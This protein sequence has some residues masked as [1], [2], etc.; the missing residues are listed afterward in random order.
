MVDR[1]SSQHRSGGGFIVSDQPKDLPAHVPDMPPTD[2]EASGGVSTP[3]KRL[4]FRQQRAAATPAAAGQPAMPAAADEDQKKDQGTQLSTETELES[5]ALDAVTIDATVPSSMPVLQ[6]PNAVKEMLMNLSGQND[7]PEIVPASEPGAATIGET[8][9]LSNPLESASPNALLQAGANKS[10]A[11][12]EPPEPRPKKYP[13]TTLKRFIWTLYSP[14]DSWVNS[15]AGYDEKI[16]AMYGTPTDEKR[17]RNIGRAIVV[18]TMVGSLGWLVKISLSMPAPWGV[19]IGLI[20][21]TLYGVLSYSLESFFASNVNPFASNW[22]KA[23]SLT[24]RGLLSAL[25]AFSGALPWVTMSLKGSIHLEMAKMG[26]QEQLTMREGIDKVTGLS[27]LTAR[28]TALQA[29]LAQWNQAVNEMPAPIQAAL[30]SADRCEAQMTEL[31]NAAPKRV[32][33]LNARLP[34]LA[35]MEESARGDSKRMAA[36]AS[37]R[38]LIGSR[39][40]KINKEVGDKRAE[41]SDL[42]KT[43]NGARADHMKMATEQR[44][45]AQMRLAQQRETEQVAVNQSRT[46]TAKADDLTKQALSENSAGEF[47]ALVNLLKTQLFAQFIATLIFMGLFLVDVL[48]LTLRLFARPGP[49]DAEKR[50]DDAI[51]MMRA[52]GREMQA[53]ILHAARREEIES[54]D[55]KKQIQREVRP[56]IRAIVLNDV[57]RFVSK[58]RNQ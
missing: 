31:V 23:L 56:H 24:G 39:I 2:P 21:A 11:V 42:R 38:Q 53:T 25:I 29:E 48:P 15:A 6:S 7:G 43:A 45:S 57:S 41:C 26:I 40:G 46:E 3:P 19:L 51:R 12:E 9:D 10:S 28:S 44:Q 20:I 47:S 27:S 33:E 4:Q 1:A 22:S 35:K 18:A 32:S 16:L 50:T 49:Y 5:A 8:G 34:V 37:E 58:Q 36:I 52:E 55:F 17:R 54:P 30:E 13:L 14:F